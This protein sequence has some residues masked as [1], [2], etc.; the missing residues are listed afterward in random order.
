MS[1]DCV[2]GVDLGGTKLLAGVVDT[3]LNVH[4]RVHRTVR[5]LGQRELLDMVVDA[6][7][8]AR[9]ATASDV[10]AVGFGIPCLI[11]QRRGMATMAVNLPL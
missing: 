8:E 2:I 10:T 9:A 11:D 1:S 5:G 3:D 7:E 6:V 4:H